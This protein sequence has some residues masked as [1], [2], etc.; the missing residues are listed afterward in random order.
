MP[1]ESDAIYPYLAPLSSTQIQI[2]FQQ[3]YQAEYAPPTIPVLSAGQAAQLAQ[4]Q[5]HRIWAEYLSDFRTARQRIVEEI[6]GVVLLDKYRSIRKK[7]LNPAWFR[8]RLSIESPSHRTISADAVDAFIKGGALRKYSRGAYEPESMAAVILCRHL[9]K[10]RERSWLPSEVPQDEEWYWV[11][12]QENPDAPLRP[13]PYPNF[14]DWLSPASLVF[15]R[16]AGASWNNV[17]WIRFGSLG[18]ISF[19]GMLQVYQQ[20][21]SILTLE[22]LPIT[23]TPQQLA[24][25]DRTQKAIESVVSGETEAPVVHMHAGLAD[26]LQVL[27]Y[28]R[29]TGLLRTT[30]KRGRGQEMN[31]FIE[32]LNGTVIRSEPLK[33]SDLMKREERLPLDWTFQEQSPDYA[34]DFAYEQNL[35]SQ[36]KMRASLVKI[37]RAQAVSIFSASSLK[38]I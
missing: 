24:T 36:E 6:D 27:S 3:R 28:K 26:S 7:E 15:T 2:S 1:T 38:T 32:L 13:C 19:A 9:N 10:I 20:N 14:P 17:A 18:A 16:W 21:P 35:E 37:L 12:C 34:S 23:L 25:W 5:F 8:S 29:S 30:I 31:C 4:E 33:L 11:W 22:E